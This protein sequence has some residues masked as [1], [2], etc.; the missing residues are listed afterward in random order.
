MSRIDPTSRDGVYL[1]N[2]VS[3]IMREWILL[4]LAVFFEITQQKQSHKK[5]NVG[6]TL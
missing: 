1:A 2:K 3:A 4:F 5:N 6:E